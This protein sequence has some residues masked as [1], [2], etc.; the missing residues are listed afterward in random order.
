MLVGYARVSTQEQDL[1]LQLDALKTVG[2]TKVFE[3]RL[4]ARSANGRLSK[5]PSSTCARATPWWSGSFSIR[6]RSI[7]HPS[8]FPGLSFDKSSLSVGAG[9]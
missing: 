4:R 7:A 8:H 1:A 6:A 3:E 9:A 5:R 2:C